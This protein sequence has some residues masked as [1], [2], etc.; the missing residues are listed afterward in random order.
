MSTGTRV[1]CLAAVVFCKVPAAY[2]EEPQPFAAGVYS[3]EITRAEVPAEAPADIL[4]LLVGEYVV[5]FTPDGRVSNVVGGQLDA[6]GRYA[7]TP[8]YLVITDE[9][10]PGHCQAERA[11]GIY[12]W[13]RDGDTI[14]FFALEDL[15]RWRAFA[16]T[17]KPWQ[18]KAT[19][20]QGSL[21]SPNDEIQLTRSAHGQAERCPRR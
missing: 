21:E 14:R 18:I 19:P 1:A 8:S 15:C 3:F 10:G 11:T 6:K 9:E 17:R 12:K 20:A 13:K 2:S 16:I 7:S 4:P 5:T